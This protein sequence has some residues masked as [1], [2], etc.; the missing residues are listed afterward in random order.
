MASHHPLRVEHRAALRVEQQATRI[1]LPGRVQVFAEESPEG[2]RHWDRADGPRRLRRLDVA[3]PHR[4]AN[5]DHARLEVDI[6]HLEGADLAAP[7][8]A[9]GRNTKERPPGL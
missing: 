9:H 4:L 5:V 2:V 8:A 7:Q 1:F 6:V 3:I